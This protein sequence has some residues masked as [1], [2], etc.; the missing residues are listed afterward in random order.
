MSDVQNLDQP[1]VLGNEDLTLRLR[2]LLS[3]QPQVPIEYHRG[4]PMMDPT[5]LR[6]EFTWDELGRE[7]EEAPR[8]EI[9]GYQ[10]KKNGD[11]YQTMSHNRYW[12]PSNAPDWAQRIVEEATRMLPVWD[13]YQGRKAW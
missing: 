6:V 2:F 5:E 11:R 10:V 7:W 8:F 12:K 3:G 13:G 4:K 9:W 1:Y